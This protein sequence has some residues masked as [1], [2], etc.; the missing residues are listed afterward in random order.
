MSDT[1]I[2]LAGQSEALGYPNTGPAPYVPTARV[3]IWTDTNGDGT[4]DA[5]NYMR[6]GANTGTLANPNVW[7]AEV[8]IAN[9]WLAEHA[10]DTSNLWIVKQGAVKGEVGLA[11]DASHLDFSPHSVGEMYDS[12]TSAINGARANL[13]GGPYAFEHYDV[14]DWMQGETDA[15]D[16][17]KAAAYETNLREFITDA[18][19]DWHVSDVSV[20]RISEVWGDVASNL[21]VRVAQ[22]A[23]SSGSDPMPNVHSFKTIGFSHLADGHFDASGLLALGHSFFDSWSI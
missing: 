9:D 15:E 20:G 7:G 3:Q 13:V 10:N 5:W 22:W 6:P 16:P 12:A 21:E 14:L 19:R 1:H 18:Q 17:T 11:F 4:P 2:I 23:V 8:S